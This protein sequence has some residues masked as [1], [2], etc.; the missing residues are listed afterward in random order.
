MMRSLTTRGVSRASLEI[1][2]SSCDEVESL[3]NSMISMQQRP[4]YGKAVAIASEPID[5][6]VHRANCLI[7][8]GRD[9]DAIKELTAVVPDTTQ[10][11]EAVTRLSLA[12]WRVGRL[13]E[14]VNLVYRIDRAQTGFTRTLG[15]TG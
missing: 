8:L 13:E 9:D 3:N 12:L 4:T 2:S 7:R 11:S 5:A 15:G 14:A 1:M 6:L 10:N